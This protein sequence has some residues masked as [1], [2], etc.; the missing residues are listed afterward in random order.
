MHSGVT[1]GKVRV[2]NCPCCDSPPVE[3]HSEEGKQRRRKLVCHYGKISMVQ[4]PLAVLA[5]LSG[6]TTIGLTVTNLQWPFF[7]CFP[8]VNGL[9]LLIAAYFGRRVGQANLDVELP[10]SVKR[11][12]VVHYVLSL[13]GVTF[14][15]LAASFSGVCLGFC[16]SDN[17]ETLAKCSPNHDVKMTFVCIDLALGLLQLPAC[18]A[19]LVLFCLH[20]RTLGFNDR[21]NSLKDEVADLRVEVAALRRGQGQGQVPPP[22]YSEAPEGGRGGGWGYSGGQGGGQGSYEYGNPAMTGYSG[23][24]DKQY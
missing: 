4:F 6:A 16:L 15:G 2:A 13:I 5:L 20:A 10:P 3:F 23:H 1:Y 22:A 7:S 18:I 21:F 24:R 11:N 9:L 12:V 14:C 19:A 8:L 17:P